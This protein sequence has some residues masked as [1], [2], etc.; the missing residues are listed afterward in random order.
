MWSSPDEE[1]SARENDK[2]QSKH[3]HKNSHLSCLPE[4]TSQGTEKLRNQ[5]PSLSYVQVT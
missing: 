5:M 1:Y 2:G 3:K 4:V